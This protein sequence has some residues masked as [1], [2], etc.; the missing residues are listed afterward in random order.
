MKIEKILYWIC[1]GLL[2]TPLLISGV[3]YLSKPLQVS[4]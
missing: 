1:T 3:M 4:Q 2:S